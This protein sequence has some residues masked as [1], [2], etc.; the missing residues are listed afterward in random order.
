MSN[1]SFADVK[2]ANADKGRRYTMHRVCLDPDLFREHEQLMVELG[3]AL[4]RREMVSRAKER[5]PERP[6]TATRLA[7]SEKTATVAAKRIEKLITDNPTAFYEIRL[8]ALERPD[9]LA[10]RAQH[11]PRDG[12]EDD[13]G[14]YNV[15]TMPE[16]AVAASMTDPEATED[17]IAFFRNKLQN[18][19]WEQMMRVIWALNEGTDDVPKAGVA[20]AYLSGSAIG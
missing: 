19:E 11:P 9:W 3:E 5:D 12:N 16:P 14:L 18:G 10:L 15:V 7:G 13:R 4:A 6:N 8:E 20:S 2:K 17:N 1:P